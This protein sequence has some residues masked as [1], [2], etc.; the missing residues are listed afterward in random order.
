MAGRLT[1][2]DLLRVMVDYFPLCCTCGYDVV[3]IF[4]ARTRVVS[5]ALECPHC[6]LV[7]SEAD[8]EAARSSRKVR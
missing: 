2:G 7:V 1:I 3:P 5:F 6:G 4:A 8:L